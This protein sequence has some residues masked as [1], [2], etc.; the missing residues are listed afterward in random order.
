MTFSTSF[1]AFLELLQEREF[2]RRSPLHNTI[3]ACSEVA[4]G[5]I[6][7]MV[8]C[9]SP[10]KI[11]QDFAGENDLHIS[12]ALL[13]CFYASYLLQVII[14]TCTSRIQVMHLL[15][16]NCSRHSIHYR[17]VLCPWLLS[18]LNSQ[19]K[20]VHAFFQRDWERSLCCSEHNFALRSCNSRSFVQDLIPCL[21]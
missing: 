18:P 4:I 8:I 11:Y 1:S 21:L 5:C 17:W 2:A 20:P 6:L 7:K 10:T 9:D 3:C 19:N 12:S 16:T 14:S 15:C 13:T